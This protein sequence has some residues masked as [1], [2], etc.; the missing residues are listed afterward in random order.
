MCYAFTESYF[1]VLSEGLKEQETK[2]C[3]E[4]LLSPFKDAEVLRVLIRGTEVAYG[5][6]QKLT[7][8]LKKLCSPL[9]VHKAPF[10]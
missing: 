10:V 7:Q 5:K 9:Q 8:N 6:G 3:L 1:R 2:T 4:I